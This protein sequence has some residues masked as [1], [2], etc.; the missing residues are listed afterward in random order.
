M[1]NSYEFECKTA[2]SQ[3]SEYTRH[4]EIVYRQLVNQVVVFISVYHGH[5]FSSWT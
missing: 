5:F 2:L 3:L 1:Y 4:R